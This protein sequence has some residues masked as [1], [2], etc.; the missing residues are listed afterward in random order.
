MIYKHPDE[1]IGEQYFESIRNLEMPAAMAVVSIAITSLSFPNVVQILASFVVLALLTSIF[2]KGS[3]FRKVKDHYLLEYKGF[4]RQ[5]KLASKSG[6]LVVSLTILWLM[7]LGK[8]DFEALIQ[9][10]T[11]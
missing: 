9:V 2:N 3:A 8:F 1:F 5:L 11:L 10:L 4:F 6:T 7:V